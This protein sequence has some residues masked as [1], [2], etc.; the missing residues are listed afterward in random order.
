MEFYAF[1]RLTTLPK[2]RRPVPNISTLATEFVSL[3]AAKTTSD[4]KTELVLQFVILKQ[5]R[6]NI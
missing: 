3:R 5:R 4:Q 1:R 2:Q 6:E